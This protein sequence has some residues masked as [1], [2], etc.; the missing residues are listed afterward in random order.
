VALAFGALFVLQSVIALCP[1]GALARGLYPW[2]YGGLFL[3][4]AF[5]RVAFGL[6]H[7]PAPAPAAAAMLPAPDAMTFPSTLSGARA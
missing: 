5:T 2:F 6:W 1:R 3:D 7:P 4:E